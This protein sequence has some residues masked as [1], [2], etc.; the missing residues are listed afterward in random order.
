VALPGERY[1]VEY[2]GQFEHLERA[3]RRLMIVVPVALTLIFALLYVTY[4]NIVDALRVFT[5]VPFAW[6]GGIFALW[7]RACHSRSPPAW[8]SSP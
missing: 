1:R 4:H 3:Q 8:A 5:G 2:G 7:L 6:V